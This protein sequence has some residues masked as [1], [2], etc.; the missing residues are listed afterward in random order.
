[1][2]EL[3]AAYVFNNYSH[4]MQDSIYKCCTLMDG[5]HY[6]DPYTSLLEIVLDS[7]NTNSELIRDK[8]L[9][10]FNLK[11][12]FILEQHKIKLTNEATL[13]EKILVLDGLMLLLDLESYEAV[14]ATLESFEPDEVKLCTILADICSVDISVIL[15]II[16]HFDTN[17][18]ATLKEFVYE[19]ER[20]K[21]KIQEP[22]TSKQHI[23]IL[24]I[25][26]KLC[27][28]EVLAH[29]YIE[30]G[31]TIGL[32]IDSYIEFWDTDLTTIEDNQLA[33]D[34]LSI[35]YL[36]K[37]GILNPI[38]TYRLKLAKLINDINKISKIEVL[39]LNMVGRVSEQLQATR[40]THD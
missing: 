40:Y 19:K 25:L 37:D 18:L 31:F 10:E 7:T 3:I 26:F 35:I 15:G 6:P 9:M 22:S 34:M 29:S 21:T 20:A 8:L 24:K 14:I 1:M 27:E 36:S 5:F 4:E 28:G 13:N 16:E 12:D 17:I 30:A 38:E 33:N 39:I 23:D 2:D 32:N 11:L